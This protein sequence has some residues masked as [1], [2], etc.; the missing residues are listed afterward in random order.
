MKYYHAAPKATMKKIVG[1]GRIR[2]TWDGVVYLCK[3]AV[4]SCKFLVIRG[5]REMSV[6]EVDI[7][8]D[9]VEESHD[10]AESFFRC[11]AYMHEGDIKLTGNE[12]V[13]DYTFD[14]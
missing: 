7:D 8:E 12:N 14:I 3:E 4:D 2:K 5:M 6:I 1:E 9:E 13:W 11:K 10:H